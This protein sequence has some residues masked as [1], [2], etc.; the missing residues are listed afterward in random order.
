MMQAEQ[1]PLAHGFVAGVNVGMGIRGQRP[2]FDMIQP[3]AVGGDAG[4]EDVTLQVVA[5][6]Q[7]SGF[8]LRAGSAALHVVDIVEDRLKALAGERTAHSLGVVAIRRQILDAL[9]EAVAPLAVQHGNVMLGFQQLGDQQAADELSAANYQN[10]HERSGDA[11][12]IVILQ[13]QVRDQILAPASSAAC[14]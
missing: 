2:V 9:A 11:G 3:V 4:R 7:R 13:A 14:S 5:A 10:F 1:S 12:L 6:G 8:D